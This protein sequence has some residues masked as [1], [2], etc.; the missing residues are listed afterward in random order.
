MAMRSN[1]FIGGEMLGIYKVILLS[2]AVFLAAN[3]GV[4]AQSSLGLTGVNLAGADFGETRL[5]GEFGKDYTYPGRDSIK[6]FAAKGM[7]V[8]R[9]PFRWERLQPRLHAPLDGAELA[10]IKKFVALARRAG[11]RVILD[12][13]NYARYHGR[14]IGA[15]EGV[16]TAAFADFWARLAQAFGSPK[17]GNRQPVI[18]GLMNEPHDMTTELWL[19]N[20]NAAIAAI[21]ATGAG[22]LILVPG[23]GWSGA[24]SWDQDYYGTPNA[25]VMRGVDDPGDNFA[26]DIH[27][28]LDRDGSGRSP[29]CVSRT[30]GVERL[31]AMTGW[32]RQQGARAFLSEFGVGANAR[33]LA[34]LDGMLGHMGANADVW[35][36]WTYW[37]AGPWWGEYIFTLEPRAGVE[38]AQMA[39]LQKHMAR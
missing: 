16:P 13:H 12:P 32:L 7:N 15:G 5:P 21:R 3:A 34:A 26:Y 22:N 18:F 20:A 23:N 24:H 9:L 28:Y 14:I 6:Y 11:A 37:A 38:R 31:Q 39:V 1:R 30:V 36:G 19:T 29:D 2:I 4:R 10:R 8:F 17:S 35:L 25:I 33:C 27:Q